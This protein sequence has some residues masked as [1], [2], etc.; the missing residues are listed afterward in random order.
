MFFVRQRIKK[1]KLTLQ[2][3]QYQGLGNVYEF[4]KKE[5]DK[6]INKK[7]AVNSYNKLN[8]ICNSKFS[9]YKYHNLDIF[10]SQNIHIYSSLN[11]YR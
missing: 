7:P 1:Q 5:D 8:I 4:H 11:I 10:L 6:G 3:K 2:K 9:F